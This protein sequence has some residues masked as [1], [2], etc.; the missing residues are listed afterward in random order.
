M[1][2]T[3]QNTDNTTIGPILLGEKLTGLNFINW[4]RNLW[5]IFRYEKKLKFVEQPIGLAPD[6]KITDSDTIDKYYKTINLE[7]SYLDT[8][9]RLGYVMPNEL[10]VI[11][12]M[13]SLNKYY[14][15]FVQHYNMHN[16]RKTIAELHTML[17]F[18]EKCILKKVETPAV[19]A[20]W[21]GKIQKDKKKP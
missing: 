3:A 14:E 11:L 20:I 1:A 17:K 9:E 13:N 18:H 8:L 16:M 12:I 7:K 6:P 5:I 10:D 19:L 2:A 15:Q 21:E 4:Y